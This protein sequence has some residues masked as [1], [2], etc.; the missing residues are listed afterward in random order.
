MVC[1]HPYFVTLVLRDPLQWQADGD[2]LYDVQ[3]PNRPEINDRARI[4]AESN[5]HFSYR[6]ILPVAYPIVRKPL[7]ALEVLA[8][9]V[10]SQATDPLET[11]CMP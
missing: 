5:G 3:Y 8:H 7:R 2:G 9:V 6:G 4:V 11:S 10:Y 1:Q